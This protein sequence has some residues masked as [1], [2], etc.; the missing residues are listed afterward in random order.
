MVEHGKSGDA[1][2]GASRRTTTAHAE[3]GAADM[4]GDIATMTV[5]EL[6]GWLKDH[7]VTGTSGMRKEQL[8]STVKTMRSDQA[9]ATGSSIPTGKKSAAGGT[10][11]VPG[12]KKST[13]GHARTTEAK[14]TI[15]TPSNGAA[16]AHTARSA[17]IDVPERAIEHE[18]VIDVLLA[19]HE[20]IKALFA[21]VNKAGATHRQ[22]TFQQLVRLIAIHETIEQQL[23]HPMSQ[24][25]L[26]DGPDLVESRVQEE[27]QATEDLS[28]LY[29]MGVD[30][31]EFEAR[32]GELRD[33]VIEHAELEEDEEFGLLREAVPREQ[34]ASLASA[35]RAAERIAPASAAQGPPTAIAERVRDALREALR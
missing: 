17:Q 6:R 8:V 18:D 32:L 10:A 25:R 13:T 26:P 11:T 23:V 20:Q 33:A 31:P 3:T 4:P 14:A 29:E 7:G 5:T 34:L 30:H 28:E 9:T 12:A 27:E 22:E 21:L 2:S 24:R 15:S 35:A 16:S 1:P 19:H